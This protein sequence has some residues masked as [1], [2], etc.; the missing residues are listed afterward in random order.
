MRK[1]LKRIQFIHRTKNEGWT[2]VWQAIDTQRMITLQQAWQ[3]V[4]RQLDPAASERGHRFRR[5][6][7]EEVLP[8]WFHVNL[9]DDQ[10]QIII[11]ED[12]PRYSA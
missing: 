5:Q 8:E 12:E 10:D 11:E 3:D 4:R 7:T 2:K 6:R 1:T 9:L